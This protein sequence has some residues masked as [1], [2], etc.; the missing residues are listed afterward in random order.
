MNCAINF[1][2]TSRAKKVFLKSIWHGK[3]SCHHRIWTWPFRFREARLDH[4]ATT[5]T[6]TT[7]VKEFKVNMKASIDRID[8]C[9]LAVCMWLTERI[10]ASFCFTPLH[11]MCCKWW[12]TAD[13]SFIL[14]TC[15]CQVM[16]TLLSVQS[17]SIREAVS[18]LITWI[19]MGCRQ[20]DRWLFSFIYI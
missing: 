14:K 6:S 4:S 5:S 1:K 20:T 18:E 8:I 17:A 13:K 7:P 15:Y 16:I 3:K 9:L 2:K 12:T 10:W 11:S 19:Q